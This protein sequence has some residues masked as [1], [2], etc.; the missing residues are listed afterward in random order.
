M[1]VA[2][3][4]SRGLPGRW[5]LPYQCDTQGALRDSL[6]MDVGALRNIFEAVYGWRGALGRALRRRKAIKYSSDSSTYSALHFMDELPTSRAYCLH[7][8][9]S[10]GADPTVMKVYT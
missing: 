1:R 5:L 2:P 9:R 4:V 10:L 8:V 3:F 7:A 6:I